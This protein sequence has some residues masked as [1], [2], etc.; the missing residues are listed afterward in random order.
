[1]P[2]GYL[3]YLWLLLRKVII[4]FLVNDMINDNI[5]I[6]LFKYLQHL[7]IPITKSSISDELEKHPDRNSLLAISEVLEYWDVA[8]E[9][10]KIHEDGLDDI[11]VPFIVFLDQNDGE[12]ALVNK[13]DK[14]FVSLSNDK[15]NNHKMP[16]G[17]FE[18]LF[19]AT[20]LIAENT[21]GA[22]LPDYKQKRKEELINNYKFPFLIVASILLLLL[23]LN[24]QP[25]YLKN[26][27]VSVAILTLLKFA[28]IVVSI[29]LLI[30]S[31]DS[32]DP[33][34]SRLCRI[35]KK[36][37]CNSILSSPAS[38]LIKGI[39]WSEVGFCY[40]TGTF[41]LLIFNSTSPAIMCILALFNLLC[42]PYTFFSIFYQWRIAKAWCPFCVSIQAIFWL[43][44]F[45]LL[46]VSKSL[47][48]L[49]LITLADVSTLMICFLLPSLLW[50][51]IKP[52]ALKVKALESV[53]GELVNF[54]YK[55]DLFEY[56][57]SNQ[58]Q[59]KLLDRE[60]SI[61]VGNSGLETVITMVSNPYCVACKKAHVT[62]NELIRV[63]DDVTLQVVFSDGDITTDPERKAVKYFLG[64]SNIV[65]N[66]ALPINH[67]YQTKGDKY[68]SLTSSFP[69]AD[70]SSVQEMLDNQSNWCDRTNIIATPTIF[71][72]GR[73]LPYGY[74]VEDL[75]YLI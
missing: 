38:N 54:K 62:L 27:T 3:T 8:N 57:L 22:G 6:T 29:L 67:W 13:V 41:L 58:A 16:R 4:E 53:K 31:V 11:P 24:L 33:L 72:N 50:A 64:L 14:D 47:S 51:F 32:N 34:I 12:F 28:G 56:Q 9:A 20:V 18:S 63:K 48:H 73:R 35:G 52:F 7:K 36:S 19:N 68:N 70:L 46:P 2:P 39:S 55:R 21:E 75:K 45:A 61:I 42:L 43:E 71:I 25:S 66:M 10:F 60:N 5:T 69:D 65:E 26:I 37:N 40:F 74:Q 15:W 49:Q 59:Y 1:M 30:Q 23:S 17:V 44:F